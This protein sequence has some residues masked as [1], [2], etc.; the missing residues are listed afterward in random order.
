MFP[1]AFPKVFC[2]RNRD[3]LA[4]RVNTV[5]LQT[6][7]VVFSWVSLS[8]EFYSGLHTEMK[9]SYFFSIPVSTC[10][11][12]F[13]FCYFFPSAANN[14]LCYFQLFSNQDKQSHQGHSTM[15]SNTEHFIEFTLQHVHAYSF[16]WY[17]NKD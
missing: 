5:F 11:W 6:K 7:L 9:R 10:Y 13:V 4:L 3:K 14:H 17:Y 15:A 12:T 8:M 2:M 1:Q 16:V